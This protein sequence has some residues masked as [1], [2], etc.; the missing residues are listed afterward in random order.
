MA[1]FVNFVLFNKYYRL[2]ENAI[3]KCI[4]NNDV[5]KDPNIIETA[6]FRMFRTHNNSIYDANQSEN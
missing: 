2:N 4:T 5:L 6:I 1:F 3:Y